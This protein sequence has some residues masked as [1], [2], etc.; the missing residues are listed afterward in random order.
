LI[1]SN[2]FINDTL[3]VTG[4][5]QWG[6]HDQNLSKKLHFMGYNLR[7]PKTERAYGKYQ[8]GKVRG[9]PDKFLH[10]F[11]FSENLK[12]INGKCWLRVRTW[13]YF[14]KIQTIIKNLIL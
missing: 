9:R 7:M 10:L 4:L 11:E 5:L 14:F 13:S 3:Q 2:D 6:S 12:D 1:K 8:N